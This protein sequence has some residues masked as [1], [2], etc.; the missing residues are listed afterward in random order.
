MINSAVMNNFL[1]L[2]AAVTLA[3]CATHAPDRDTKAQV[4]YAEFVRN[5]RANGLDKA[6]ANHDGEITWEEWQK[7]DTTPDA[8]KHFDSLDTNKDGKV[9]A[10]EWKEGLERTGVSMSLFKRLDTNQD[11]VLGSDELSHQPVSGLFQLRF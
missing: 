10:E 6:D 7:F 8:R 3:G 1:R 5:M 2:L 4:S 9:S 11:G